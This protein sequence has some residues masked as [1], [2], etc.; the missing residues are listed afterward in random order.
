MFNYYT[1]KEMLEVLIMLH[2]KTPICLLRNEGDDETPYQKNVGD[3]VHAVDGFY[4]EL[5]VILAH[6]KNLF[7]VACIEPYPYMVYLHVNPVIYN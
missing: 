4:P 7:T 5:P 3:L 1:H 2:P 6:K